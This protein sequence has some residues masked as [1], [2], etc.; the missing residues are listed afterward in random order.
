MHY[1]RK[2][3]KLDEDP[4]DNYL[5]HDSKQLAPLIC[6]KEPLSIE[7]QVILAKF[8]EYT[9]QSETISQYSLQHN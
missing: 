2:Q 5:F 7:E 8:I 3:F 1:E 4:F 9:M 6:H